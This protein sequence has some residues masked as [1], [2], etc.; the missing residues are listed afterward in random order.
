MSR[1]KRIVFW[2]ITLLP[3][4]ML[5]GLGLLFASGY[6]A[7]KLGPYTTWFNHHLR[8]KAEQS[9]LVGASVNRVVAV[10]GSPDNIMEFWERTGADGRPAPGA[11]FVTTYEYYP[12]PWLPFSKFQVHT[13]RG[14]VRSLEM[15]DD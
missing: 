6:E 15:F 7:A 4:Y 11:E 3:T 1:L 14:V 9:H 8:A 2:Q 10:L 5:G 13:T 12:Y